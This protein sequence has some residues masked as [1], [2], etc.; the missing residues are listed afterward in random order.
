MDYA[1]FTMTIDDIKKQQDEYASWSE[2]CNDNG[3]QIFKT[4][5]VY[6]CRPYAEPLENMVEEARKYRDMLLE[7]E[8][9]PFICNPYRWEN[10]SEE[11]KLNLL[12]YRQ[13]LLD[14]PQLPEFP[15]VE[16]MNFEAWQYVA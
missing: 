10:I 7:K 1:N 4:D 12:A 14:V 15:N 6:A 11:E 9:D 16:I 2:W 13:Y 8:V 3:Y 5:G